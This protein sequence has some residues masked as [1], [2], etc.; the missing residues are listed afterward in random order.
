MASKGTLKLSQIKSRQ[1]KEIK[2]ITSSLNS[3][4]TVT[5]DANFQ[6]SNMITAEDLAKNLGI[7]GSTLKHITK[8]SLNQI[9]SDLNNYYSRW[10]D[11]LVS[12]NYIALAINISEDFAK[13]A[14]KDAGGDLDQMR[15]VDWIDVLSK[16][17]SGFENV[18][19]GT[20]PGKGGKGNIHTFNMSGGPTGMKGSA[21]ELLFGISPER[22]G[23]SSAAD[24]RAEVKNTIT[25]KVDY[26]YNELKFYGPGQTKYKVGELTKEI[27]VG[28]EK[29][30]FETVILE[31]AFNKFL[32]LLVFI[33][34]MVRPA[35][36]SDITTRFGLSLYD[37]RQT[38]S[39]DYVREFFVDDILSDKSSDYM[40]DIIKLA[41]EST[42]FDIKRDTYE[43]DKNQTRFNDIV[44]ID[45]FSS[46][47]NNQFDYVYNAI[48]LG[49]E[50]YKDNFNYKDSK[51]IAGSYYKR[52]ELLAKTRLSSY[53][54]SAIKSFDRKSKNLP[55]EVKG[56]LLK[57]V[58]NQ[59]GEGNI[60]DN[61]TFSIIGSL[62]TLDSMTLYS[63]LK[64][65]E[66]F[67]TIYKTLTYEYETKI[68][69]SISS[70]KPDKSLPLSIEV[71]FKNGKV[72]MLIG[73]TSGFFAEE[74]K[75]KAKTKSAGYSLL[76]KN[77]HEY[78][79]KSNKSAF[80][81][82]LLSDRA[83]YFRDLGMSQEEIDADKGYG[84]KKHFNFM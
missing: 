22:T 78:F 31:A 48:V 68:K 29:K 83:K 73:L 23:F 40:D 71:T 21:M 3:K 30:A 27:E 64:F 38:A 49:V 19:V 75:G 25:G 42:W 79:N 26:I 47:I 20:K 66:F 24:F 81:T 76:Y 61:D 15:A 80:F 41:T 4:G 37:I 6:K 11:F 39:E 2:D 9:E 57:K 5:L 51:K 28:E 43:S 7:K 14:S 74:K 45:K 12:L 44:D 54:L 70:L 82:K 1:S 17:E 8:G 13:D 58:A 53:V 55:E 36:I 35:T 56:L 34:N 77:K 63:G 69:K 84:F 33:G 32:N 50:N 72:T 18:T 67:E 16:K 59:Y 60:S 62:S 52:Y 65:K 10:T 46:L